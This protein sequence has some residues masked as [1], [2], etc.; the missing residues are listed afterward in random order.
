MRH[1]KKRIGLVLSLL[2]SFALGCTTARNCAVFVLDAWGS[3]F[4]DECEAKDRW[5]NP[6]DYQRD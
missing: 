6:E 3:D 2:T 5:Q 1:L 4:H